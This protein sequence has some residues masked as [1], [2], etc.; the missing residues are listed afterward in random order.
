MSNF[1]RE[2][3]VEPAFDK[4]DPDPRKNY[5][6]HGVTLRFHLIGEEG[7][8][9]FVVYTSMHL[10]HVAEE[11]WEKHAGTGWNP[12]KPM[13]ADIGYHSPRPMYEGHSPMDG[14]CELIGGRTCYYDGS[15]LAADKFFPEFLAGG[16]EAVWKMLEEVYRERFLPQEVAGAH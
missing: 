8:T 4:R 11:L 9:Q 7:A 14:P 1:R 16:D 5:G 13:A 3:R 15:G 6:I 10:P 12:F 2:I